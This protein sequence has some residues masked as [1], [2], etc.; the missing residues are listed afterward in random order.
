MRRYETIIILDPDLSEETRTPV[1]ERLQELIPQKDGFLVLIDEWGSKK[2]A[3]EIKKKE[4]GY[5]IRLDFCGN[6]ALV[7]EIERFFRIDDRVLKYMTVLIDPDADLDAIQREQAEAQAKKEA[8]ETQAQTAAPPD[9]PDTDTRS[10]ETTET[11]SESP[12]QTEQPEAVE[13]SGVQNPD[14]SEAVD[15]ETVEP[16]QTES[17]MKEEASPSEEG[18]KEAK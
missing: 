5:Y 16:E 4:R 12:A 13:T 11:E 1:L 10:H 2:L 9:Q 14:M 3:Y 7:D 8:A 6:G 18:Q 17:E 15:G